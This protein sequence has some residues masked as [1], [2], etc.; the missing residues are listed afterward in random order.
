AGA[1]IEHLLVSPYGRAL[2]TAEAIAAAAGDP[3]ITVHPWL[4]EWFP[5]A[6]L[7]DLPSTRFEEMMR[8]D[9]ERY[10]DECWK[11]D[12]GEGCYEMHARI[13]PP[14]YA[15]LA[16]LG[17]LRRL[18]GWVP[19]AVAERRIVAIVAHGGSLGV[20][21]SAILGL[22]PFPIAPLSFQLGGVAVIT[23]TLRRGIGYP[24]LVVPAPG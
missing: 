2:Q 9:G 24:H 3:P 23:F 8:R 16:A 7:K 15:E 19:D 11:T 17:L 18:G 14:L 5:D 12:L 20:V 22:P 6:A 4:R 13:V 10:V 1:G 21:A